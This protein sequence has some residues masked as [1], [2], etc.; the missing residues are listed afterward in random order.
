MMFLQQEERSE[1]I[2][3]ALKKQQMAMMMVMMMMRVRTMKGLPPIQGDRVHIL[4]ES[5]SPLRSVHPKT[6]QSGDRNLSGRL[7][8]HQRGRNLRHPRNQRHESVSPGNGRISLH[9]P[10]HNFPSHPNHRCRSSYKPTAGKDMVE[11]WIEKDE[12]KKTK[13]EIDAIPSFRT[14]MLRVML[15][16]KVFRCLELIHRIPGTVEDQFP[17]PEHNTA[18]ERRLGKVSSS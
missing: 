9:C 5:A 3:S 13:R 4:S 14:C 6:V 11:K 17:R 16:E 10:E 7:R 12:G 1:T 2:N 8:S 15:P 18:E